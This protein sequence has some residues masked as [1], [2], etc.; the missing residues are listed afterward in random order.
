MKIRHLSCAAL[1]A[2]AGV[3]F[4]QSAAAQDGER[5][6]WG[7]LKAGSSDGTIPAWDGGLPTS[8]NP[9]GFKKDSGFWMDPYAG[10]K[11][12]YTVTAKNLEQ[13]A[14]KLSEATRELL[15]RYPS[16]RVDVYPTRRPVNYSQPFIENT[17]KNAAGRCKTIE[18]GE[19][20]IGCFGGV[21]F[22]NPKTGYEAMWNLI[23]VN[24]GASSW[25]YGQ[26]WYVDASGNKVMTGEVNNRNQNDYFNK[27]LSAE[28]FYA[29]GGQYLMNNNIYSAPAR[30]NG[31]GN[32]QRKYVNPVAV[33]DKTWNYTPGQRRVRLSPDAAYDFPV[34]T[35]GG[36]MLYDEIYSFS[37]KLDRFEWKLVGTKEML[38]PYNAYKYLSSKA[39]DLMMK[40]HPNP[41][42]VRW[43]LHRVIVVEASL[44]QGA[45]HVVAKRRFYF[46]EDMADSVVVDAWD[47]TGKLSRG[48]LSPVAWAYDKQTI[49]HGGT[50]YFDFG[51][52]AWYNSSVL[53]GSKGVFIETDQVD[54]DSFYSPE[55]LA[56]RT[57]R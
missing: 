8:T 11:I 7:A 12:L 9:P 45:R 29:K 1:L 23:L 48:I 38:I 15:K 4:M 34:A 5:L 35:S 56:R 44:R 47:A 6:P 32:L 2:T 33:P 16:F 54:A 17:Q 50:F 57:Q 24:K 51:T 27:N 18:D 19:A 46:D 41:D 36:A 26:A 42:F 14:D 13:H 52:G 53:G 37:G 28:Q 49:I 3:G 21:P 10:D 25:T 55:G 39:D 43:E 40:G 31:E 30:I 22:P 20:V